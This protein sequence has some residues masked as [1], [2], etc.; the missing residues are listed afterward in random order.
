MTQ[1]EA[2]A[3]LASHSGTQFDPVVVAALTALERALPAAGADAV[4]P[5]PRDPP[6]ASDATFAV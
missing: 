3:E 5:I 6:L 1:G 2:F 4:K